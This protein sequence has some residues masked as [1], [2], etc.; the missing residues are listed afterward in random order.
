[1]EPAQTKPPCD[2]QV[3]ST[4]NL[5]HIR[6]LG[7]LTVDR[8]KV[9]LET[10][11]AA[12]PKLRPGFTLLTDLTVMESMELDCVTDL[13]KIM[14]LCRS[15]GIATVIRIIPDP[16]KDIG[17]MMLGIVHYRGRRVR[18]VTCRNAAEAQRALKS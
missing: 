8:M 17:L 16:T 7:H 9:Y 18:V 10:V 11:R 3:D 5:I 4:R 13:T 14:D 6:Y 1:M 2:V 15:H 12:L